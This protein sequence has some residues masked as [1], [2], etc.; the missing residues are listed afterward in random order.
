M[1][2][3]DRTTSYVGL[4][5]ILGSGS[6]AVVT[7]ARRKNSSFDTHV[8]KVIRPEVKRYYE[9]DLNA[10]RSALVTYGG[11]TDLRIDIDRI[12]VELRQ[13]VSEELDLT[14]EKSNSKLISFFRKRGQS[15][16]ASPIISHAAPDILEMEIVRGVSL[17]KIEEEMK[18]G[19]SMISEKKLRDIHGKVMDDFFMQFMKFGIFHTDLHQGNIIY[20]HETDQIVELD[21]A[22]SG[23]E[24]S[25]R[26]REFLFLFTL[27]IMVRDYELIADACCYFKQGIHPNEVIEFLNKHG[28]T[29]LINATT[30]F[31][32]EKDY[33]GSIVRYSKALANIVPYAR[34][35]GKIRLAMIA[36]PYISPEILR[37]CF[38]ASTSIIHALLKT[39]P[40]MDDSYH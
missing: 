14:Y 30:R 16:I 7:V 35:L 6:T 3:N 10:V 38:P 17:A 37:R 25:K 13:M 4:G 23:I 32:S 11:L 19:N 8:V 34:D 2:R 15:P 1:Q 12:L 20:D 9:E 40:M 18:N 29:D 27:G 31:L 5:N 36:M 39:N 28:R 33:N 22:Q 26:G 24:D 21:Y